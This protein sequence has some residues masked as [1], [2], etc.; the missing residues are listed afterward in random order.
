[1]NSRSMTIAL[2]TLCLAGNVCRSVPGPRSVLPASADRGLVAHWT[3]DEGT[4]SVAKDVTGNG[5]DAALKNI[6]WVPS[7][8]GHALRFDSKEDLADYAQVDTMNL[9]GDMTLAVWVK[10]DS[11]VDPKTTRLIF[12]DGGYGIERN[13]NLR[14]CGYGSLRF[15]WAD[16][17]TT[18]S[19]LAPISHMNGTWKHVVVVANSEDRLAMM[20]VDGREVARMAMPLPISKA[21]VK[22]RSTGWF[23]NGYFQGEL[24]DIR[25]YAR[26]LS[27]AEVEQLFVAQADLQFGELT[28][29]FDA[30]QPEPRGVVSMK[31]SN[32][33]REPRRIEVD[34]PLAAGREIA[35]KP[36]EEAEV[37]LGT[38]PLDP[39]WAG[40]TDLWFC[41][42]P[43]ERAKA[44]VR[45]HRGNQVEEMGLALTSQLALE[46]LRLHIESPWQ[47]QMRAGRT[48]RLE[49]DLKFA[50]PAE[51]L[52]QGSLQVR[53]VSRE[54]G[55]EALR[56]QLKAPTASM[57]MTLDVNALPWG[58]YDLRASFHDGAGR[59]VV[60]TR[61]TA[62]F[63][64]SGKQ[65]IRVLNNLVS[66]L[67]D[68]RARGLL[69]SPRVEFMNPRHGWVWFQA[70]GDCVLQLGEQQL[71]LAKGGESAAEAMRLLPAGKHTLAV[72]GKPTDII[73]R[74]IPALV[75][76]LYPSAPQIRPFGSNTWERL[77]KHMLPSTNMIESNVVDT[78]ES[79]EWLAQGKYWLANVQA[80]GLID[81]KEW[82]VETL[83]DLWLHPGKSTAWA[84]RPKLA[85]AKLSGIQVDEYGPGSKSLLT[86]IRSIAR[87]AED[88][89][90]A[91]KLWIPFVSQ[92]MFGN[93]TAE[94]FMKTS[95]GS[96]WPYSVEVYLGEMP[97]EKENLQSIRSRF[98]TVAANWESA[99]PGS[100]RRAIFV[101][102]Y[103]YLPYIYGNRS[104]QA[105]FRVHLDMQM[106]TL[107][108]A[109]AFFGLWG[110]QP[111]RSNYVNEEINN[112]MGMLF[113]HY[114]IE[115]K[116]GRMLSAPYELRHVT[117]PDFEE[118]TAH[119]KIAPAEDGS[120]SANQFAGYGQHQGRY[121]GGTTFGD[122]FVVMTR[123]AKG[124]NTLGQELRGLK[125]GRLYS[126]KLITGD[127]AD[128]RGSKSRKDQ[129]TISLTVDGAEVLDGGFSYPFRS[130]GVKPFTRKAPFWMTYH[131][132][133]FRATGSTAKLTISDW[134]KPDAPGGPVGQQVM[135]NFVELQP[136]L[137]AQ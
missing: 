8:R 53:L 6:E 70:A 107:A 123:S 66:E 52:R 17:K 45:V 75:Y 25:L 29:L 49:L 21:P 24:D 94:L 23:Y 36:G 26:A 38:V 77:K 14:L 124:P 5:H 39:V 134:G 64:P 110:V 117:D 32:K 69:G 34:G 84:E 133:R 126:L 62:V 109:P 135:Y 103:C 78:P 44:S 73:V 20:Y 111:Y 43:R 121:P 16:G 131:W 127:Y 91:G 108:S 4:G 92:R 115:G 59:E 74:A 33:S 9:S 113:R 87:L 82:T 83:L 81:K 125:K 93:P 128:L 54:T 119:W 41:G 10:T 88:P 101:P 72:T 67:M 137:E 118:G 100:V 85:L 57:T 3:F 7:P 28:V 60:T 102:Y 56:R 47:R 96:G 112:C 22:K 42:Q 99:Y 136:V 18:A 90:F 76:N 129:Q 55:R 120:I 80:P 40:R 114:C 35:L 97:T 79:R 65:Q 89:A 106:Q 122:T 11:S 68:A 2:L 95:M 105:D 116:T 51:Q 48:E 98:L 130:R 104:P 132:L 31:L 19:L 46:P 1:M 71:L 37:V 13:L 12:G 50:I 27:Q 30:S 86:T 63:L 15:E 61:Q 58:A